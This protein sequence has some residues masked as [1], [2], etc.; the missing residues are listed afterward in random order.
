MDIGC[1]SLTRPLLDYRFR[2]SQNGLAF[3]SGAD[4]D[5]AIVTSQ[6]TALDCKGRADARRPVEGSRRCGTP[7]APVIGDDLDVASPDHPDAG[8]RACSDRRRLGST[9]RSRA[10][11]RARPCCLGHGVRRRIGL[12]SIPIIH[13]TYRGCGCC[14]PRQKSQPGKFAI[15]ASM[16]FVG[17]HDRCTCFDPAPIAR[18]AVLLRAR[19]NSRAYGDGSKGNKGREVTH[20]LIPTAPSG[21]VPR[22]QAAG[23]VE[24]F[25]RSE[26]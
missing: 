16:P 5:T 1:I 6:G 11:R 19:R 10:D 24:R 20:R 2:R 12:H 26:G 25:G 17:A 22:P 8:D 13:S 23:R 14:R 4:F 3:E 7:A 9:Y 15:E 18:Q 21:Y